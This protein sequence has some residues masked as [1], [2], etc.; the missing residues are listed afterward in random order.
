M[1]IVTMI[2]GSVAAMFLDKQW[3]ASHYYLPDIYAL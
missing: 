3:E 1:S 2:F